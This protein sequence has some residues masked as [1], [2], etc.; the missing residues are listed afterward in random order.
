MRLL[1]LNSFDRLL[2]MVQLHTVISIVVRHSS[3]ALTLPGL[4]RVS[5]ICK[6]CLLTGL[7]YT[8]GQLTFRTHAAV[9]RICISHRERKTWLM[10]H[11]LA[12]LCLLVEGGLVLDQ[13]TFAMQ[14]GM[15]LE[16]QNF[17][18]DIRGGYRR[19]SGYTK[20]NPNI[21]PQD[22]ASTEKV[23]MCAYFQGKGNCCTRHKDT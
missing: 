18:P 10:K 9:R 13:S 23:L 16:L 20:W 21:V 3:T 4:K 19:I 15:A 8:C 7:Y 6:A 1:F 11:N 22:A 2:W 12:R 17:E 5:N 14:P